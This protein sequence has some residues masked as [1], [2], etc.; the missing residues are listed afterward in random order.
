MA[1]LPMYLLDDD[2]NLVVDRFNQDGSLAWLI[3]VDTGRWRAAPHLDRVSVA[4]V[5]LWHV[6]SGPL[7]LF[8]SGR[9]KA[10]GEIP[11]P[12]A[13]WQVDHGGL[14]YFGAGHPGVYWLN[15]RTA[16]PEPIGMSTIEW[17]GNHYRSIG[18]PATSETVRHWKALR[19]WADRMGDRIP[20]AGPIGGPG[21]EIF[22]FPSALAAIKVGRSRLPNPF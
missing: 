11:D 22:A 4:R 3:N 10:E 17:I 12:W 5:G 6:P 19:R 15:L 20:R 21:K 9:G 8:A 1:W 16:A 2:V 7:P 14:P 13:G 18:R